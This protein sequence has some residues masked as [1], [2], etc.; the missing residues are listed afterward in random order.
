MVEIFATGRDLVDLYG[1]DSGEA[2]KEMNHPVMPKRVGYLY[3][4]MLDKD[5]IRVVILDSARH[6]YRR[7]EVRKVLTHLEKYVERTYKILS[8]E[9]M[10][11]PGQSSRQ[12]MTTAAKEADGS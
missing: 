11:R 12:F 6:K 10:C 7:R 1:S 4:K 2:K 5:L 9:A 8:E 3:D